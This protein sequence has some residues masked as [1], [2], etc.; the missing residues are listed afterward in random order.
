MQ[1]PSVIGGSTRRSLFVAKGRLL[2]TGS[3]EY[4]VYASREGAAP[5]KRFEPDSSGEKRIYGKART[6]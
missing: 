1:G 5:S 4:A 6:R 2:G 3:I